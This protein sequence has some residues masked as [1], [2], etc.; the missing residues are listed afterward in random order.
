MP[1][2]IDEQMTTLDRQKNPAFEVCDVVLFMAYKDEELVGTITGIINRKS[3]EIWHQKNA[4]FGFVDFIE[5]LEV[6]RALFGAVEAWARKMGMEA[7]HGPLGFTDMDEEGMLIEGFDQ[8]GTMAAI[9]NYPY[10]PQYMTEMGFVKDHDWQEFKIY[11]PEK[12]PEKHERI[13]NLV[14]RKFGLKVL[15]FKKS[16]EI[17]PYA[18][19]IFKTLNAAYSPL[20]GFAPLTDKQIE[21]YVKMYIPM[22]RLDL[23]TIILRE[24]DD[25]VVGFGISLPNLSRAMQKAKGRLFP[26]GFIPLL[27]GLYS[28]PKVIDLYLVGVLPEYHNKGVNA[29][30]FE[31]L[32]PIY[33]Q[34]GVEYAETN[35]ELES[36][37][38]VQSQWEYFQCEHHKTRRA[39]IKKL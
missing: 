31:D 16:K 34:L 8:L 30:L 22:L 36:N 35:P 12:M 20:F 2:L 17:W 23:V 39:F 21:Y 19:K 14:R 15:K 25:E 28:K 3:N 18:R 4:R 29:L 37:Q 32:I 33:Q 38:A 7:L 27:K 9:Y 13:S 26:F 24:S 11:I 5:D 10:Y 6:T 1:V